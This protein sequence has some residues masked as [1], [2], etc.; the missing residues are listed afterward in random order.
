MATTFVFQEGIV[1]KQKSHT[2]KRGKKNYDR[3]RL[4]QIDPANATKMRQLRADKVKQ[5]QLLRGSRGTQV[6]TIKAEL[7]RH[8]G[9]LTRQEKADT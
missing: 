8:K 7:T 9:E 1:P 6:R 4:C 5:I 3:Y 2:K